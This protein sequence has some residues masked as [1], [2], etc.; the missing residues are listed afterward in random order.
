VKRPLT[1]VLVAVT[2]LA[3]MALVYF[4][5]IDSLPLAAG[6]KVIASTGFLATAISV[7]ALQH[8]Y[9]RILFIGLVLSFAGDMMLIGVSQGRFLLG[10]GSF[11]L[12]HLAYITAFATFGINRKW[13]LMS[14]LPVLLAAAAATLWLKPYLAPYLIM[15][16]HA[17]IGVISLMVI[18]AFACKGAG[19]STLVAVGAL[20]F[21][22]SDLSVAAQ[23]IVVVDFP[24]IIWGLP[25]YYAGQLC[26]ALSSSQSSSQ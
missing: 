9:G 16:V 21:F 22:V 4:L 12:A 14:A 1:I 8:R 5:R 11:L 23:S 6:A 18:A 7:G 2:A 10:L 19:G 3:V 25:L 17:Y 15:P 24:T 13:A 20:L 26:F